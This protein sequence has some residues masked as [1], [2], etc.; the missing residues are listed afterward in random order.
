MAKLLRQKS[1]VLVAFGACATM[2]GI[3]GLANVVDARRRSRTSSTRSSPSI[4]NP[5]ERLPAG[6]RARSPEG[7]LDLPHLYDTVKTLAQ[8]VRRRLLHARLRRPRPTRSAAVLTAVIGGAQGQGRAAAQGRRPRRRPQDLLRRV[9]ARQ[10][11]EE[12]QRLQAHLGVHP[13]AREVPA[14]AGHHLHGPGDAR[15]LRRPLHHGRHALPRLLRRRPRASSTRAPRCSAR[16][17]RSSTRRRPRRSPRSRPPC[18]IRWARSTASV[19]PSSL[20][21]RARV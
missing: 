2:G 9:R 14:R 18:P 7:E 13:R 20:L 6:A 11:R 12:D 3:P 8:T 10:G 21:R 19:S 15:R 1:K 17:R 4:D 16:W 5:D